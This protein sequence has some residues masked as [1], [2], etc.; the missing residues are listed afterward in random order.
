MLENNYWTSTDYNRD[1]VCADIHSGLARLTRFIPIEVE[2]SEIDSHSLAF[3]V[4]V[5]AAFGALV[6]SAVGFLI[7][8][9]TALSI[10]FGGMV[11]AYIS[12]R[13]FEMARR[14]P[15][16]L[17]T[18]RLWVT[19][20]GG[21]LAVRATW[22]ALRG[23]LGGGA[24]SVAEA[25]LLWVFAAL[26]RPARPTTSS[27]QLNAAAFDRLR[28]ESDLTLCLLW[29]SPER[30]SS[31]DLV[32]EPQE[33]ALAGPICTALS[34]LRRDLASNVT[35]ADLRSSLET[36]FQ[37]FEENGYDWNIRRHLDRQW[38]QG[39]RGERRAPHPRR[40]QAEAQPR[41][42]M[43]REA[44]PTGSRASFDT[45]Q[46]LTRLQSCQPAGVFCATIPCYVRLCAQMPLPSD[47]ANNNF[48]SSRVLKNLLCQ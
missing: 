42:S 23:D 34:D 22:Q 6:L 16:V 25:M 20:A 40:G 19:A 33:T 13:A 29:T 2:P 17:K 43:N 39:C 14:N 47:Y 7:P 41:A 21:G 37:R 18:M 30:F 28:W 5:C 48:V 11:G 44:V 1:I 36:L 31:V 24:R 3:S 12:T 46:P 4:A 35:P 45:S 9:A 8:G 32:S 26:L 15:K 27:Q 10:L 38:P